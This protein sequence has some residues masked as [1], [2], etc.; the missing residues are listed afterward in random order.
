MTMRIIMIVLVILTG[1][2]VLVGCG[3]AESKT[4]QAYRAAGV[5]E[6]SGTITFDSKPL[7]H[8]QIQF[9]ENENLGSA[10]SYGVT[11]A[12]GRYQMRVDSRRT[13]TLPGDKIVRVWTTKR[14]IDFDPLMQGEYNNKEIIPVQ[15]NREST[16]KITVEPGKRQ[17][18]NFDLKSEGKVD[19]TPAP[20]FGE[21]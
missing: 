10:Y 20:H 21:E 17:T 1:F 3:G 7:A 14:G 11:D 13:G 8:A 2:T 16:Q 6:V 4:A 12:N 15:Y 18:F 19:P 5:A 9:S